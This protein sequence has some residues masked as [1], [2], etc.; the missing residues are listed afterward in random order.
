MKASNPQGLGSYSLSSAF[1]WISRLPSTVGISILLVS[2]TVIC[3]ATAIKFSTPS[4]PLRSLF[5]TAVLCLLL[6]MGLTRWSTS[7]QTPRETAVAVASEI[8]VFQGSNEA[9]P[10]VMNS[11]IAEGEAVRILQERG[12]WSKIESSSGIR[13]W[14]Q[15]EFFEK[16]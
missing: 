3:I 2:W 1:N 13:G 14:V 9:T 5:A 6:G 10:P 7:S 4:L 15:S 11:A 12:N 16:V 8:T